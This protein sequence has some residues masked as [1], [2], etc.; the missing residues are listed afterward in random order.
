[1]G[2]P[3][4]AFSVLILEDQALIALHIEDV[5]RRIGG[6]AIGCAAG[7]SEALNLL[8]TTTW[9]AA[10]L[11][12]RL[13][14]GEMAFPVADRLRAKAIPFAFVTAWDGEIDR[15]YSDVP[16]LR[17]PF[18]EAELESCLRSLLVE[19]PQPSAKQASAA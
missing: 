3:E 12:L 9:N 4:R 11:D 18:G 5:V 15:R 1:M 7:I 6:G 16:V 17:K 10:L 2:S 19:A 14:R 13:A 8:D